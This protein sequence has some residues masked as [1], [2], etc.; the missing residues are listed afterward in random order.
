[1]MSEILAIDNKLGTFTGEDT[2]ASLLHEINGKLDELGM[3]NPVQFSAGSYST[4]KPTSAN[5]VNLEKSSKVTLTVR[6]RDDMSA[7]FRVT[8][9]IQNGASSWQPL[10]FIASG[11]SYTDCATTVEFTT[12][13]NGKFYFDVTGATFTAFIYSAESA[14]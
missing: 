4:T 3:V 13:A 10:T 12:G 9:Y 8:V 6:V 7:G 5:P 2:V 14:P 11:A 1:M